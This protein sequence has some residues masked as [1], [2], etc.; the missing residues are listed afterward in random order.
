MIC[1]LSDPIL[2]LA[3]HFF[4]PINFVQAN[5]QKIILSSNIV[6]TVQSGS[7]F[8]LTRTNLTECSPVMRT[9]RDGAQTCAE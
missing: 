6:L 5:S 8:Q 9:Q 1:I 4:L 7:L 2:S 3:T